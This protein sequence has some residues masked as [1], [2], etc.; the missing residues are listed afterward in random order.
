[1]FEKNPPNWVNG[2][3]IPNYS[4]SVYWKKN[5]AKILNSTKFDHTKNSFIYDPL[6]IKTVYPWKL[7]EN[8]AMHSRET[9]FIRF[10]D[11][12][13]D[14]QVKCF[15]PSTLRGHDMLMIK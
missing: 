9:A 5:P 6:H 10:E 15:K 3:Q 8:V 13:T 1:M 2:V 14:R 4:Y 12:Q 11:I 7:E